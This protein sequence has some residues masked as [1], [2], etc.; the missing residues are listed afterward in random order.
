MPNDPHAYIDIS[1]S[2]SVCLSVSVSVA[3]LRLNSSKYASDLSCDLLALRLPNLCIKALL[4]QM[5]VV[6]M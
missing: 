1:V 4:H 5:Q 3:T 2:V 6:A